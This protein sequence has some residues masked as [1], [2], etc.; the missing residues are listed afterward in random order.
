[1]RDELRLVAPGLMLGIGSMR[2][3]G[4]VMNAAPFVLHGKHKKMR[5]YQ[6]GGMYVTERPPAN[7]D[8]VKGRAWQLIRGCE[9]GTRGCVVGGSAGI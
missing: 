9:V 1:M 8:A 5:S 2:V 4:G 3:T 7:D 6:L